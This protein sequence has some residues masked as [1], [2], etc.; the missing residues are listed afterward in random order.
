ME[1]IVRLSVSRRRR[2]P[3]GEPR[4]VEVVTPRTNA[5]ALTSAENFFAAISL[6]E[7]F[8]V[9]VAA[10]ASRRQFLLRG[11]SARMEQQLLSQVGA[12]YPQ[13]ELR[14]LPPAADPAL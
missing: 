5:A 6:A 9:E 11:G 12:T 1:S 2:E 7:P 14:A 4:V 10:D 3:P 8:S 13:A